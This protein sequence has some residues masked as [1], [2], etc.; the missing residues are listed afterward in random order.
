LTPKQARFVAEYLVDLNAT[1]AAIRAGY[2]A[3]TAKQQGTR[4]LSKAAVSAAIANGSQEHIERAGMTADEVIAAIVEIARGD[5]RGMFDENGSLKRPAEWDDATAAAVAG[6]DVVTVRAG[7][8]EVEHVAKI[9]R[10]DR[11]RALDMLCRYHSL[12]N[13]KLDVSVTDGLADRLR[14]AK[15]KAARG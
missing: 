2:S 9:R 15:E 11:L 5:I 13:D 7:E 1:Q 3:R 10:T 4:L 14:A 12:Y 6:L 8:G